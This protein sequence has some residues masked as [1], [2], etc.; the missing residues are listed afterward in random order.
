MEPVG[1]GAALECEEVI[2]LLRF[3]IQLIAGVASSLPLLLYGHGGEF[4]EARLEAQDGTLN[5]RIVA[6][7]GDNPMIADEAEARKVLADAVRIEVGTAGKNQRLD[8]L[9]PLVMAPRAARDTGS[10]M[11]KTAEDSSHSDKLLEASWTWPATEENVNFLVPETS[12]QVVLF[13]IPAPGEKTPR[14]SLLIPG[15]RTPAIFVKLPW[16]RARWV[17]GVGV[18]LVLLVTATVYLYLRRRALNREMI[19]Q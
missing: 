1:S 13:W 12:G 8:E 7:Y 16:W 6:Q 11:P 14:W 2:R 10:P 5:L 18:G 9:T 15:D 3:I 17:A 4:L 19:M